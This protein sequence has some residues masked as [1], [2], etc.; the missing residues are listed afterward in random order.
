MWDGN[1]RKLDY[2]DHCTTINV[3]N[4]LSDLKKEKEKLF[5]LYNTEDNLTNGPRI[6]CLYFS[7]Q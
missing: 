4:S 7:Q 1:A 6:P 2:D 3:I 5:V